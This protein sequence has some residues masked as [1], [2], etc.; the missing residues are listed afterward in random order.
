MS[1]L[2][3]PTTP[4]TCPS[5]CAQHSGFDDGS[6]DWHESQ[7][8]QVGRHRVYVSTGSITG[9]PEVFMDDYEGVPLEEAERFA[10]V[11]LE[12]VEAAR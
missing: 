9:G 7:R 6:S 5:W 3:L 8:V 11:I 10:Q 4:T 2:S 12:L 1:V